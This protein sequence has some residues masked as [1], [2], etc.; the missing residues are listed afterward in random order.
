MT[1]PWPG[2]P[3][4]PRGG[5]CEIILTYHEENI[6][7][8]FIWLAGAGFGS[9]NVYPV[10]GDYRAQDQG[11]NNNNFHIFEITPFYSNVFPVWYV[12]WGCNNLFSREAAKFLSYLLKQIHL[13]TCWLIIKRC[14]TC[15]LWLF[16]LWGFNISQSDRRYHK[17]KTEDRRAVK[18][19]LSQT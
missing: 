5:F 6:L 7:R 9:E 10:G 18:S 3:V 8:D 19:C 16:I 13:Y 11:K 12:L 17:H 2:R 14:L 4:P 1:M 15:F